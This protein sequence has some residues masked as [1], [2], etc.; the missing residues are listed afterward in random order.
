VRCLFVSFLVGCNFGASS[1]VEGLDT[2]GLPAEIPGEGP[3]GGGV[4][5]GD[6]TA[7]DVV[8]DPQDVDDDGDGYTENE[9]DCDDDDATSRPGLVDVCDG[10]DNDCDGFIDEDAASE[11]AYEPNDSLDFDLG[12]L[13]AVGIFE[14]VGFL[15]DEDDV[16]RFRFVY[17]D[18]WTDFDA[19]DVSLTGLTDGITYKM[20][21]FNLDTGDTVYEAFATPSDEV[22]AFSLESG[23]G[24]D[25]AE[26]RVQISSL[27]G[28]GCTTPY[29]LTI[30]HSD[31]WG[32]AAS[33]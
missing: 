4:A 13:D 17:A 31:L 2:G 27:G 21:V 30:I 33:L 7:D 6:D 29:R 12:D 8:E 5:D 25:S 19:L 26:F 1:K 9:G 10:E 3:D 14:I 28:A 15:H 24:S 22:L 20:K 23:F 18:S 16:D 11:D 32:Y